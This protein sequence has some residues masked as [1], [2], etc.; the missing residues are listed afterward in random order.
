[1]RE[2][3]RLFCQKQTIACVCPSV[4]KSVLRRR[5]YER[6]PTR[7]A[8]RRL[9]LSKFDWNNSGGSAVVFANAGSESVVGVPCAMV[10]AWP[11]ILS[12]TPCCFKHQRCLGCVCVH[13]CVCVCAFV[14]VCVRER[15]RASIHT[16]D[17][18]TNVAGGHQAACSSAPSPSAPLPPASA[19]IPSSSPATPSEPNSSS[20]AKTAHGPSASGSR[21]AEEPSGQGGA[22]ASRFGVPVFGSAMPLF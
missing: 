5:A 15:E 8:E 17:S 19:C 22:G 10:C 12:H 20:P 6:R 3:L 16:C 14:C 18:H 11:Q 7:V 21:F 9:P 2:T 4:L 1:M 13:V